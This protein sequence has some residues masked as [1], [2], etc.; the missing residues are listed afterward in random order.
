MCIY[1][2]TCTYARL[3]AGLERRPA[4]RVA[5]GREH[6]LGKKIMGIIIGNSNRK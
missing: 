1:I 5:P 2:H 3:A 4:A 6:H